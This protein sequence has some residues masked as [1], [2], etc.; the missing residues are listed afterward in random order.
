MEEDCHIS[1]VDIINIVD[2]LIK[3]N[4]ITLTFKVIKSLYDNFNKNET[5]TDK[6]V[7]IL[8]FYTNK[9]YVKDILKLIENEANQYYDENTSNYHK[10]INAIKTQILIDEF[11]LR[12]KD[13][14]AI[15][16]K[17]RGTI[18]FYSSDK[19]VM[20]SLENKLIRDKIKQKLPEI[21][22]KYLK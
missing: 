21:N 16:N 13:I 15:L 12:N 19:E 4:G 6:Q 17:S 2:D 7:S 9:N 11:K 1:Y 18:S 14:A 8:L 10:L 5:K 3:K 22:R 20:L